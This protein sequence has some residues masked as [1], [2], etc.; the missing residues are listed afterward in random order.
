MKAVVDRIVQYANRY[1]LTNVETGEVLGTFDFDEI[2]GTVQ[3]VG[4]EIDKELFDSIANDLAARVVSAGGELAGTIVTFSDISGTA[5][6]V[7][8]G[9]TSA[10][11]WGKV[12]NWFSRLKALAFKDKVSNTDIA[13]DAAI[14]QSKIDRLTDALAEKQPTITGAATSIT[15][16]NL[17]E[18]R[19]VISDVNGKV[20]VSPVTETEL[21]YLDGVTENIQTQIDKIEDGT[22]TVGEAEHAKKNDYNLGAYDTYV[23][24]GDGT[25]SITRKTGYVVINSE[26]ITKLKT[27]NN[28]RY[29]ETNV[30]ITDVNGTAWQH[31]VGKCSQPLTV[32]IG[33]D[34]SLING[35]LKNVILIRYLI[36]SNFYNNGAIILQKE[37]LETLQDYKNLCPLYIQYELLTSYTE[38]VI[39]NQ[40]IH[41]LDQNGEEWLRDEWEKG[42]NLNS[43]NG[44]NGGANG[45]TYV[46]DEDAQTL[47]LNSSG[48]PNNAIFMT[49]IER[50]P[51]GKYSVVTEVLSGTVSP[52]HIRVGMH[53]SD[54]STNGWQASNIP[55][56][57][58]ITT[59]HFYTAQTSNV[60]LMT[61]YE[62]A[63]TTTVTDFKVRI[64][65]YRGNVEYPWY[66]YNG[67]I[68]R[69]KDIDSTLGG[70]VPKID[71]DDEPSV[72]LN[73]L[74]AAGMYRLNKNIANAPS[75]VRFSYGQLLVIS[76]GG[77]TVAQIITSYQTAVNTYIRS[78]NPLAS[79]GTW[80]PWGKIFFQN[81]LST[82]TVNNAN[83]LGGVAANKY[84]LKTDI[85]SVPDA[86]T[87]VKGIALLG[88][89]GGAARYGQKGDVGLGNVTND[90]QVKRSEMGVANGVATLDSSGKVPQSQLSNGGSGGNPADWGT[91]GVYAEKVINEGLIYGLKIFYKSIDNPTGAWQT[92]ELNQNTAQYYATFK[93][94]Y[95]VFY[96]QADEAQGASSGGEA[97][98]ICQGYSSNGN[99]SG[100][101]DPLC[102]SAFTY[103]APNAQGEYD[104]SVKNVMNFGD[105]NNGYISSDTQEIAL[106]ISGDGLY[107][108]GAIIKMTAPATTCVPRVQSIEGFSGTVIP[109]LYF[110]TTNMET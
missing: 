106:P 49:L 33:D 74:T 95:G 103:E 45:V 31:T 78:G 44:G 61:P 46:W 4:T 13:D 25:V 23:S 3:Q 87:T 41:T 30:F 77:D 20:A 98:V 67:D 52:G 50:L 64:A 24:N 105:I 19:A 2:T 29:V 36:S 85:T 94:A 11:L 93:P 7:A 48:S 66:P 91:V 18:S 110:A 8:S 96:I 101:S 40:P 16:N 35:N 5:A 86:T 76:G 62:G 9:D 102:A 57:A 53:Y 28:I 17:T 92:I 60:V 99:L 34:T 107:P 56:S 63:A 65:I 71:L 55:L 88:A 6:N 22:T 59:L 39:E 69:Q 42:L 58:G 47:T 27:D 75:G 97:V 26:N 21:G 68:I 73:E 72:D 109:I 54:D 38:Q 82:S 10:T 12:K 89:S 15:N 100:G 51:A 84:A 70:Y 80:Q 14:A 79:A 37:N 90:A 43:Y 104:F 83:N 81:E 1:Q 108:N 32:M